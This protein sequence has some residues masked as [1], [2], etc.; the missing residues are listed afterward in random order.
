MAQRADPKGPDL[1]GAGRMLS[2]GIGK[3]FVLGLLP[4]A[5]LNYLIRELPFLPEM[6]WRFIA[7]LTLV[8][9]G[10]AT[11]S[12][13]IMMDNKSPVVPLGFFGIHL[14]QY[15]LTGKVYGPGK[16]ILLPGD[17]ELVEM[18]DGRDKDVDPPPFEELAKD[19]VPVW[20]D[21]YAVVAVID[22]ILY[23]SRVE[24]DD[25]LRVLSELLDAEMRLFAAQWKRAADL[26]AM[27]ELLTEFLVLPAGDPDTDEYKGTEEYKKLREAL[28]AI[29]GPEPDKLLDVAAVNNILADAG[30]FKLR[31]EEWGLV[32]K[33]VHTEKVDLPKR[34]KDAAADV[35]AQKKVMETYAIKQASRLRMVQ[36]LKKELPDL[37]GREALNAIDLL[38]GLSINRTLFE[39]DV[40]GLEKIADTYGPAVA[41]AIRAIARRMKMKGA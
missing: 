28:L 9:L 20:L 8:A 36:E 11:A 40:R 16:P 30:K 37:T 25:A 34:I 23:R 24:E 41:K 31:A 35:A 22:P 1:I 19:T 18:V 21:A 3:A 17:L 7:A 2:T 38:L 26:V 29:A 10:V 6:E 33:Q 15:S 5:L 27:R 32:V 14:V 12:F 4:A 13:F 39:L